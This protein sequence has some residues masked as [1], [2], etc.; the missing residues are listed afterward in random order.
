MG[1]VDWFVA[2]SEAVE[3]VGETMRGGGRMIATAEAP[4]LSITS[5]NKVSIFNIF[6]AAAQRQQLLRVI[7]HTARPSLKQT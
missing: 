1:R 4:M 3:P 7:Y 5:L 2:N 6:N